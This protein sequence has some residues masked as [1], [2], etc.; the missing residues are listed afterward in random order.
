MPRRAEDIG[1]YDVVAAEWGSNIAKIVF[2]SGQGI[3]PA[4][5]DVLEVYC[6]ILPFGVMIFAQLKIDESFEPDGIREEME[7]YMYSLIREAKVI[8]SP[9]ANVMKE[10]QEKFLMFNG[11]EFDEEKPFETQE[12]QIQ[13][14]LSMLKGKGTTGTG[15]GEGPNGGK[16]FCFN[17]CEAGHFASQ[18]DKPRKKALIKGQPKEPVR[19]GRASILLLTYLRQPDSKCAPLLTKNRPRGN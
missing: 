11:H 19:K 17:C 8:A 16:G 2:Y 1:D 15:K 14:L 13:G 4:Q 10:V 18:C 7:K 3:F 12:G 9:L 6:N 5:G